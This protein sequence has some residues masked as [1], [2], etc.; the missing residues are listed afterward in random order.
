MYTELLGCD[1]LVD[2]DELWRR[3]NWMSRD[4]VGIL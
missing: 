4:L 3:S 2:P 1:T